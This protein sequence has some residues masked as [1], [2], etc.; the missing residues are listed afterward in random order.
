MNKYV[1]GVLT[2]L[3]QEEIDERN[4]PKPI[5]TQQTDAISELKQTR[6]NR[7]YG[8]FSFNGNFYGKNELDSNNIASAGF[9]LTAGIMT[10]SEATGGYW[11]NT[12]GISVP[13]TK[14][15]FI[16]MSRGLAL[17]QLKNLRA[18]HTA[19]DDIN[20]ATNLAEIQGI[21]DT[22]NYFNPLLG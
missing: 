5:T 16:E 7:A 20:K 18:C 1:N 10:V 15:K 22:Y 21:Q 17:F 13:F 3:T 12:E 11:K 14:E 9:A 4:K 2:P 8:G 19:E 6:T